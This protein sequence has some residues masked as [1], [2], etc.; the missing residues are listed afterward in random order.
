MCGLRFAAQ[1]KMMSHLMKD[2]G[3]KLWKFL[4]D[5]YITSLIKWY[6][7]NQINRYIIMQNKL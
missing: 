1:E 4:D 7:P 6:T 3:I 2:H 5:F